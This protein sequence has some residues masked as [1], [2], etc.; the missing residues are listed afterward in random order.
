VD[1]LI[2]IVNTYSNHGLCSTPM[3]FYMDSGIGR[4]AQD[5]CVFSEVNIMSAGTCCVPKSEGPSQF[6]VGLFYFKNSDDTFLWEEYELKLETLGW[7]EFF[8]KQVEE[9]INDEYAVGRVILEH[10]HLYRVYSEYGELLADITGK[11]RHQALERQEF[12]AVGDWVIMSVRAEEKKATIHSVLPRKSKFSRKIAGTTTEEQIVA[13]NIDTVFLVNALN[14]DFN[15]RRL[16]RYL[17]MAWESGA[18][19][20]I[21]LSKSDLCDDLSETIREVESVALGVP[22]HAISAAQSE[23]IGELSCYLKEGLTVALLGSSGAGKST[24]VNKLYGKEIQEVKEVRQGDDRGQHTTTFRELIILPGGGLVI[25]TPG[26]REL[27]LWDSEESLQDSFR[28]IEDIAN[29]C[30]FNDCQHQSEPGCAVK[31]ALDDGSLDSARYQNYRKL[32]RELAFLAAKEDQ[33]ERLKQKDQR[34][35]LTQFARQKK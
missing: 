8:E 6:R 13:S 11:L 21:I 20:V 1:D 9:V 7:N 15:L 22:I 32:Q 23:G 31:Q 27:Q 28:D 4:C 14:H 2:F 30:H 34:K 25:D 26:M 5:V 33:K 24:L 29:L 16:E 17:V 35:K 3:V 19:P 10:K 18:N 12:P